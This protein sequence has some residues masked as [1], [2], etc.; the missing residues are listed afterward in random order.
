ML[1]RITAGLV[2]PL[3]CLVCMATE[4]WAEEEPVYA[5]DFSDAGEEN[6][7]L[8]H[9]SQVKDGKLVCNQGAFELF[10]TPETPVKVSFKVRELQ[11]FRGADHHWGF[12]LHGG[13]GY[14]DHVYTRGT[15]H[16]AIST[17]RRNKS[18]VGTVTGGKKAVIS[19]GE[20]E[21]WSKVDVYVGKKTFGVSING[22]SCIVQDV[23]LLP[24]KKV[25]F[26]GY[27]VKFEIDDV[28]VTRL[29]E[30]RIKLIEQPVFAASF[31]GTLAATG[32]DGQL[33]SPATSRG[34][35]FLP[36]V[37]G[38]GF[39]CEQN[40]PLL[41]I[42]Y[43]PKDRWQITERK[44][45]Q[46][47][48]VVQVLV[49]NLKDFVFEARF[50]RLGNVPRQDH[51]FN[52]GISSAGKHV[53]A[54]H[55]RDNSWMHRS[56]KPGEQ[57]RSFKAENKVKNN[58]DEEPIRFRLTRKA[59]KLTVSLDG[60]SYDLGNPD[61]GEVSGLGFNGYGVKYKIDDLK[62]SGGDFS[63]EEDFN[64]RPPGPQVPGVTYALEE[65]FDDKVGGVSFWVRSNDGKHLGLFSLT[66]ERPG[67]EGQRFSASLG[68][69]ATFSVKR[70]DAKNTLYYMRRLTIFPGDWFHVAL[71]WEE[72]G[73]ARLF[74]NGLPYPVCFA[75][76]QRCPLFFNADV[77]GIRQLLLSRRGDYTLDELKFY[78]R[79]LSNSE[80]YDEYRSVMPIDLVMERS[81]IDGEAGE[82]IT[83][84]AAPGG[85]YMLPYPVPGKPFVKAQVTMKLELFNAEGEKL[86]TE[87]KELA[88]DKPV[89]VS[90]DG[91]KLPVGN[92]RLLA[93]IHYNDRTFRRT[94]EVASFTERVASEVSKA[95][96]KLGKVIF[97]KNFTD[98]ADKEL[99][100]EG[101][102]VSG[103]LNGTDYLEAGTNKRDRLGTVVSFPAEF[104]GKP[105]VL[106]IEWPDD[107]VR[108]MGLYMYRES[109]G[110]QHRD[111]LQ[112]GIQAGNEYPNGHRIEK[113]RY[114]FFPGMEHYLFEART[115]AP[116]HPA[117]VSS[118]RAYEVVGELPRLAIHYPENMEGRH[119]GHF[120]ED[121]TF[122][123]NLRIDNELTEEYPRKTLQQNHDLMR[124]FDYT[125]QNTMHYPTW[126]YS[127]SFN[128][129]E[130]SI[131]NGLY[132]GKVGELAYVFD[133][134]HRHN[135]KY[136]AMVNFFT[137]PDMSVTESIQYDF[138]GKG[139]LSLDRFGNVKTSFGRYKVANI[140]HPEVRR[141][142]IHYFRSTV[143]RYA[144]H[145]G[146]GGIEWWMNFGTW[147]GLD[148]GY[149][150]Y[151]VN[152]FARA[153][154]TRVPEKPQERYELLTKEPARSKWLK[155]RSEQVTE[156]IREMRDMLDEYNP[157]LRLNLAIKQRADLYAEKGVDLAAIERVKDVTLVAERQPTSYRWHS[158]WGKPE[159]TVSE[160]M[161][162]AAAPM[163]KH[164][165]VDGA[166]GAV[167]AMNTYF[168]SFNDSLIPKRF[169]AYFQDADPKQHG[170]FF[171]KEP[172]FAV[173]AMD[174]L[175][176]VIGGQPFGSLGRD[177][178][179]REFT[180]AYCALPA[181]PFKTAP[182]LNDPAIARYLHTRNGT[183]FYVVNMHHSSVKVEIEF[184]KRLFSSGTVKYLDLSTDKMR[185][186]TVIE[187]L[188]FQLRSFLIPRKRI[189]LVGTKLADVPPETDALY[190]KRLSSL[191]DAIV[192]LA[193]NK[194]DVEAEKEVVSSI[195]SALSARLFAEAHRLAFSRRMNQALQMVRDIKNISRRQELI[196]QGI[197]RVNCGST[198]FHEAPNGKFF[199]PDQPFDGLYGYVGSY[200]SVGRELGQI[201]GT[202][203]PEIFRTES[204]DISNYK[205]KVPNGTYKAILY[206]K[207]G[208]RRG[209][210]KGNFEFS[211][212]ANGAMALYKYDLFTATGGDYDKAL[213]AEIKDIK[214]TN[215]ILSLE[216]LFHP[217]PTGTA[218]GTSR[219][220]NAIEIVS[221][222]AKDE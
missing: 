88:V 158:F 136:V 7:K 197:Y 102:T 113:A 175:E 129:L 183:Y 138:A 165:L 9:G 196:G 217:S 181:R 112:S 87:R 122:T 39:S 70:S 58:V 84:Q 64:K 48:D 23:A 49:P 170:R 57:Y 147:T 153:T 195:Q 123:T 213:T 157:A 78:H 92:Y 80:A 125:G 68:H 77:A 166:A 40:L 216:F 31:D 91:I 101:I 119:F 178:E 35:R 95:P 145:P 141:M 173:G 184:K 22:E 201:R 44:E 191:K 135:K 100:S 98:P 54:L 160:E 121:Q 126:R 219:L 15:G 90:M 198:S 72:S 65:P 148:C 89:D 18:Q 2:I 218:N 159:P 114:L 154:G 133:S 4:A 32:A 104:I 192:A 182:G 146:F 99:V 79:P 162:D 200:N 71:T 167:V 190:R 180:Q 187:L 115:Y 110:K 62:V 94:F 53:F 82:P 76:G 25:T 17:L 41:G 179:T 130:G 108:N 6:Y 152:A 30:K 174:A 164:F 208:Y 149:D 106:E 28:K 172:A 52:F 120:D 26:Y 194:V 105:V 11:L 16:G 21:P 13:D 55:V 73:N 103:S 134:F 209:F 42:K 177:D 45:F 47:H 131:G 81:I 83:L 67:K 168:E 27:R 220:A 204:Y 85:T 50:Q 156:F 5:Q 150:D 24:L 109:K 36:G 1:K 222:K 221:E 56:N 19:R 75:A 193:K 210:K 161:Y 33:I 46:G 69:G 142:F 20:N 3:L 202:D 132:P 151:T 38:M 63:L 124:Y 61:L 14:H 176:F 107:K 34:H 143:R 203:M 128:P 60:K 111:R 118:I 66:D 155:W 185:S 199:F 93:T 86:K 59:G 37:S 188:P 96:Y 169:A 10:F 12:H 127:Y 29:E 8:T 51:H 140:T 43:F 117:A 137:L 211:V 189:K 205:F 186:S 144:D 163:V 116:G 74:V 215:G 212:K 214:V 139:M 171:L 207:C 97:E 206:L